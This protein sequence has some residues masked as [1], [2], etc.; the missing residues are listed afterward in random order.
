MPHRTVSA[1]AGLWLALSLP[2]FAAATATP[3][4][5]PAFG[6]VDVTQPL[7]H[8]EVLWDH[9]TIDAVTALLK[10]PPGGK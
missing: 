9:H 3:A 6:G 8:G 4:A 2:L 10:I 1:L 7:H 5:L